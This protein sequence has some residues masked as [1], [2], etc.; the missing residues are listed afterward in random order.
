[1]FG[2][3]EY[4]FDMLDSVDR[5]FNPGGA[6]S[7]KR[8][9][10]SF[11]PRL[12]YVGL[13]TTGH[14]LTVGK[15]WSTYYQVA[16]WTDWMRG[17][18]GSALGVYNA[19]TDGGPTGTGR[20]DSVLQARLTFDVLPSRGFKPLDVNV[21]VQEGRLIPHTDSLDYGLT[22]GASTVIALKNNYFFGLAFNYAQVDDVDDPEAQAVHLLG[23]TQAYTLALRKF[24]E[25]KTGT[26]RS[27]WPDC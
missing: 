15:N 23:D 1:L 12:Y 10:D 13:E 3:V 9:F 4:G 22:V 5:L 17:D 8:T 14:Y 7:D 24:T 16:G 11:F 20:A 25:E 18:G 26:Q 19:Q 21:Q 6:G 27:V 2:L